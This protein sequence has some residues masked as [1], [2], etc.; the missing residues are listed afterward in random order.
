MDK[1]ARSTSKIRKQREQTRRLSAGSERRQEIVQSLRGKFRK[2]SSSNNLL[3]DRYYQ[4]TL[5][6]AHENDGVN[7]LLMMIR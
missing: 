4:K 6:Q 3:K 2:S 7:Q 1:A 5:I